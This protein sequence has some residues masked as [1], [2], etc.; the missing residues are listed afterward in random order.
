MLYI[1]SLDNRFKP[2]L[3]P[4]VTWAEKVRTVLLAPDCG[5]THLGNEIAEE[6][7]M[8]PMLEN[9]IVLLWLQLLPPALSQLVKE[10]FGTHICKQTLA[11][12]KSEISQVSLV[13][14]QQVGLDR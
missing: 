14:T 7:E 6:E 11:F 2:F 5:L 9:L 4:G 1:L 12:I 13:T 8:T 3:R 10:T